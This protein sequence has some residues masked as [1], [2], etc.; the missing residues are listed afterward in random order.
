MAR[1]FGANKKYIEHEIPHISSLMSTEIDEVIRESDVIVVSKPEKEYR[2]ALL[3]YLG[4]KTIIDLVRLP[5]D[6]DTK[7]EHYDGICW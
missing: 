5:F 6:F 3:P 1:I 4:K 7:P 2:D